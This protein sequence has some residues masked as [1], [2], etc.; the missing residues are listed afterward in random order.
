MG[1][2]GTPTARHLR[3]LARRLRRRVTPQ[4]ADPARPHHPP[5]IGIAAVAKLL[6][7]PRGS[8]AWVYGGH[9]RRA[10]TGPGVGYDRAA[11]TQAICRRYAPA[12]TAMPYDTNVCAVH[13]C[14]GLPGAGLLAVAG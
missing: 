10:Q 5:P 13:G 1:N 7:M 6:G 2:R 14:E 3:D 4:L 9:R 12:Q 8:V 11:L